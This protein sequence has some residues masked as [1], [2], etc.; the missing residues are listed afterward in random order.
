MKFKHYILAGV[1]AL[2]FGMVVNTLTPDTALGSRYYQPFKNVRY[3]MPAS[4]R[5]TYYNSYGDTMKVN[6]YS[7]YTNGQADYKSSWSGWRKLAFAKVSKKYYTL[8]AY[9][10]MGA[11]SSRRWKMYRKG[12]NTYLYHIGAMNSRAKWKKYVKP[13]KYKTAK[14]NGF[15]FDDYSSAYLQADYGSQKLYTSS[16]SAQKKSGKHITVKSIYHKYYAKWDNEGKDDVL[17]IRYGSKTYFIKANGEFQPYNSWFDSSIKRIYS[18]YSPSSKSKIVFPHGE[19]YSKAKY[20]SKV[21]YFRGGTL[22]T[23]SW[24]M[25]NGKWVSEY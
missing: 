19:K 20:W 13:I 1:T 6:K 8:N 7:I 24:K 25:N 18:P 10:T 21:Q 9:A 2:S 3:S 12:G 23:N 14:Y 16:S 5:G 11:N 4:W 17:R 22:D 15:Y